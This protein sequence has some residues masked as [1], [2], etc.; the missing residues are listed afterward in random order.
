MDLTRQTYG[1]IGFDKTRIR[2][3]NG[4]IFEFDRVKM[5]FTGL[6]A[7]CG[8]PLSSHC[9]LASRCL[10]VLLHPIRGHPAGP[11]SVPVGP[12]PPLQC[13][14]R[15]LLLLRRIRP[16][17]L[18]RRLLLVL[19]QLTLLLFRRPLA[20]RATRFLPLLAVLSTNVW[21]PSLLPFPPRGTLLQPL[22]PLRPLQPIPSVLLLYR[23]VL[24]PMHCCNL[25]SLGSRMP[26]LYK[27]FPAL[28][29]STTLSS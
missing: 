5:P 28:S 4:R 17:P 22:Q 19:S 20:Y 15:P 12:L 10:V 13:I 18:R 24:P 9:C 14:R 8:L 16:P 21:L 3:S 2:R 1:D 6:S 27:L 11:Q 29:T 23:W 7:H 26:Q 25:M